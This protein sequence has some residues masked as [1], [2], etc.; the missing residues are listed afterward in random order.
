MMKK[1][2]FL[3]FISLFVCFGSNAEDRLK[4]TL[5]PKS[6]RYIFLDNKP[7]EF[8]VENTSNEPVTV[9]VPLET[10]PYWGGYKTLWFVSLDGKTAPPVTNKPPMASEAPQKKGLVTLKPGE[11]VV[12]DRGY[13]TTQKFGVYKVWGVFVMNPET[14]HDEYRKKLGKNAGKL[15]SFE[16]HSDTLT[17]DLAAKCAPLEKE[18]DYKALT[19]VKQLNSSVISYDYTEMAYNNVF[20]SPTIDFTHYVRLEIKPTD[21]WESMVENIYMMKNVRSLKLTLEGDEVIPD[22]VKEFKDLVSLT[23]TVKDN[24]KKKIPLKGLEELSILKS[25]QYLELNNTYIDKCP[26]W[27]INSPTIRALVI[28]NSFIDYSEVGSIANLEKLSISITNEQQAAIS[29]AKATKLEDLSIRNYAATLPKDFLQNLKNL[30]I[31]NVEALK[32]EFVP[33]L[34]GL[35]Q[36]EDLKITLENNIAG[37]YPVGMEGLTALKR[38]NMRGSFNNIPFPDLS[39]CQKLEFMDISDRSMTQVP[40][41]LKALKLRVGDY[42]LRAPKV[43]DDQK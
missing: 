3:L 27:I 17:Y 21:D 22:Y 40:E 41:T 39:G 24:Q 1:T 31:V 32:I 11:S 18:P 20:Y 33:E 43:P 13:L 38:L 14:L 28:P 4:L 10:E 7:F 5:V 16:L 2:I 26:E 15:E 42:K 30:K 29:L 36:I 8:K 37:Y 9:I 23:I 12:V 6:G 19:V 25:L 34:T 35:N